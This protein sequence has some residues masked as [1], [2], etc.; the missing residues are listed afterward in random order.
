MGKYDR[1]TTPNKI[2]E[3]KQVVITKQPS[4]QATVVAMPHESIRKA[5][6][7]IGKET[8]SYRL[9]GEEKEGL[10]DL[11]YAFR[12]QGLRTNENEIM[13]IALNLMLEDYRDNGK[14]SGLVQVLERLNS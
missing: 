4:N 9:S 2:V 13:R 8:T 7:S 11:V 1:L 14:T 10:H 6:R 12:K 5:V 3:D